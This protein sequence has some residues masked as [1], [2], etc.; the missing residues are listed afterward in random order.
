[1]VVAFL[2]DDAETVQHLDPRR[3]FEQDLGEGR[4]RL[5]E[6]A[7]CAE[8]VGPVV[9]R[10]IEVGADVQGLGE[11]VHGGLPPVEGGQAVAAGDQGFDHA[12]AGR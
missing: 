9:A 7:E 4:L 1:M 5:I 11:A 2:C 6:P 10:D 3:P 8:R 12:G